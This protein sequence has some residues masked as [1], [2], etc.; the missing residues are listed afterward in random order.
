V[1]IRGDP[2]ECYRDTP[3]LSSF[4]TAGKKIIFVLTKSSRKSLARLRYRKKKMGK[5]KEEKAN[6]PD[7]KG[8]SRERGCP[9]KKRP[10]SGNGVRKN[11]KNLRGKREGLNKG[12]FKGG[13]RGPQRI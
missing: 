12:S 8:S 7:I 4:R 1:R 13:G 3:G 10:V 9:G 11:S 5:R 2:T 6:D